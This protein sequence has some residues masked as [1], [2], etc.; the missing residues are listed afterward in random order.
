[1]LTELLFFAPRRHPLAARSTHELSAKD[2]TFAPNHTVP[3]IRVPEGIY[4]NW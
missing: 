2:R 1:M 3:A 4:L